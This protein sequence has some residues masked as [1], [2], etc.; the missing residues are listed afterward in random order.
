MIKKLIERLKL[1]IRNWQDYPLREGTV[2]CGRYELERFLG[3][4]SYGQAYEAFD[5]RTGVHVLVKLN[6]P[7]KGAVGR[8]LLRRESELMRQL[9]HAQIPR[10]Q[11]NCRAG[12]RHLLVMELIDGD[13]L[14]SLMMEQGYRYDELTTAHILL[15]LLEPL[16]HLHERGY[17]HRDVRIPNVMQSSDADRPMSQRIFLI[18][19][20]L[21]CR[22]GEQL[23][24][25]LRIA[26][27]EH[28]E[29]EADGSWAGVKQRM[30][31]PE[32]ASDFYGLG[33]LALFLLYSGYT[34]KEVEEAG[35]WQKELALSA[36]MKEWILR[37]LG[38]KDPFVSASEGAVYLERL[39][40]EMQQS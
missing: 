17:V 26:L 9:S 12:R 8:E 11:D 3:M 23:P 32:P 27:G 37:A 25:A 24:E 36:G 1:A 15:A 38:D 14:E 21:A 16:S 39:V 29:A 10:W 13:N 7:S 28:E 33:H 2:L 40:E 6:K 18:D 34:P 4:G 35:D 30:R 22:I 5:R 19:Y 31:R 20:G